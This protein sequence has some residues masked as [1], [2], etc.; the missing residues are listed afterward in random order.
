MSV[1]KVS[2]LMAKVGWRE[3]FDE[4][5]STKRA[6]GRAPRTLK[7]LIVNIFDPLPCS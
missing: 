1:F 6:E 7:C 3:A 4:F 2:H 5:L